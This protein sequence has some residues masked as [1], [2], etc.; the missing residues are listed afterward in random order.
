MDSVKLS[1]SLRAGLSGHYPRN[2]TFSKTDWDAIAPF[3]FPIA[4]SHDIT[5]T[6]VA[7]TLLDQRLVIWRTN[8][9][10]SVAND[11]C[12][13]RGVPMS[14]GHLHNDQ[15]ICKYHGFHYDA[16]GN[17]TLIPANPEATISKRLCL[18]TY[19]VRE[20]YG[21]VWTTLTGDGSNANLPHLPEWDDVSYQSI[22]PDS[23]DINAAVGRQMEGFL[24]VAHFA[25]VH[26]EAFASRDNPVVPPYTVTSTPQ[27]L[28]AEYTSTVSNFPKALQHRAPND[29]QW[30]R[31]FDVFLPFAAILRVHFPEDDRLCILN[32]PSPISARKTRLFSP[33]CRNF[34]QDQPLEPVYEFNRQIFSED[35]EVVEAQYPEDLPLDLRTEYHIPADKTSIAYRKGLADLGLSKVYTA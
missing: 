23:I 9:G 20:A 11:L 28:R 8:Q 16:A 10:L 34:D 27:G 25:W 21:L 26:H 31:V 32:A 19:P 6:P 1:K 35:Q 5:D 30:L 14:M 12:I 3:W 33:L 4:F 7:A 22:L 2:C 29:F 13:H 15:L 24:D 17:C 18:K